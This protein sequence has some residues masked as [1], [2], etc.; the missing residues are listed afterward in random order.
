MYTMGDVARMSLRKCY[1]DPDSWREDYP[2]LPGAVSGED[3]LFRLF[4]VDAEIL[5]DHAWGL[6]PTRMEDIKQYRPSSSSICSGQVL[7]CSYTSSQACLVLREMVDSMALELVGRQLVTN[8]V[9]LDVGYDR[10]VPSSYRGQLHRDRYGRT[11]PKPSHGSVRLDSYSSSGQQIMEAAV[12]LYREITDDQLLVHR[13]TVTFSGVISEEEAR[14]KARTQYEQLNLFDYLAQQEDPEESLRR[15]E[16]EE[17]ERKMQ[18]A[19]LR[20]KGK[21]GKNAIVK[22]MNLEEGATMMERNGQI[23]GH[24]A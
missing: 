22:G 3:L 18:E 14:E 2:A 8:Q 10:E 11:V 1:Y 21:Y 16:R 9:V 4:G 13:L 17:K 19:M 5:I 23:G 12:K 15:Q 24:R 20:I 6:E 7:G